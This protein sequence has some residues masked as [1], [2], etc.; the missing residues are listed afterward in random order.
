MRGT[1]QLTGA[2]IIGVLVLAVV[3][4]FSVRALGSNGGDDETVQSSPA[5]T[6]TA[7]AEAEPTATPSPTPSPTPTPTPEPVLQ[8]CY[9]P[10]D[11]AAST[12][13]LPASEGS[14]F[15]QCQLVAYY[16][17]PEAEGMGVLGEGA[18]P[19]MIARLQSEADAYEATNGGRSVVPTFHMIAAAA[20]AGPT[21]DGSYLYRLS[22]E[23]VE[24]WIALAE[25][26]DFVILLDIQMGHSTVEAEV[27]HFIE[28]LK[29]PRVHLALDPEWA[30]RLSGVAPGQ[31]IGNMDASE[32]NKAQ[33][34]LQELVEEHNLDNKILVIHQFQEQ[35]IRNKDQ[36][37]QFP[38]VDL[39][40]HMD[41]FGGRANKISGYERYVAQDGA[42]HGGFKLFYDW[43]VDFM[44]PEVVN[45][46]TPQPD[47]VTFQ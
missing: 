4:V 22:D 39:V 7:T 25:E 12:N 28:H 23:Q 35:M 32:I 11:P 43:D 41:G 13:L 16:G 36:L 20:Q 40:I 15:Q 9:E 10:R 47:V 2:V 19:D 45:A 6:A 30:M 26:H 5:E 34:M 29:H 42:P 38:N 46:L 24:T 33:E 17:H 14:L 8:H 1:P 21:G 3:A 44:P 27:E 37:Q 31:Q 18:V